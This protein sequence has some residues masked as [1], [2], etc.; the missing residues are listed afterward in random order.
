[1]T[2]W[3][4]TQMRWDLFGQYSPGRFDYVEQVDANM[5]KVYYTLGWVDYSPFPVLRR[6]IR[7]QDGTTGIK[8]VHFIQNWEF[9]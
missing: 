8:V 6:E 2:G 3:R 4:H 9:A 5:S 7:L 1:M